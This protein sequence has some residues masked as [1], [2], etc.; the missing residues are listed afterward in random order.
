MFP[1]GVAALGYGLCLWK[2][3]TVLVHSFEV[4]RVFLDQSSMDFAGLLMSLTDSI[5]QEANF[6]FEN[7]AW[8]EHG[9]HLELII[10]AMDCCSSLE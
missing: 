2:L 7:W 4:P 1:I 9:A 5:S 6:S 8:W 10:I 3:Y